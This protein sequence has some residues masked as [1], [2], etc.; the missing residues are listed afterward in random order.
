MAPL[1][2]NEYRKSGE[3]R[4]HH[5]VKTM[6]ILIEA[7]QGE[8]ATTIPQ[9]STL[10]VNNGSGSAGHLNN[11]KGEDIVYSCRKLQAA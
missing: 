3:L 4:G 9:G 1:F 10:Q 7:P 6:A 2:R 5:N 11:M 8:R